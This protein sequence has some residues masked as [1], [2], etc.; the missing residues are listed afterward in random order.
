MN[1]LSTKDAIAY[2][3]EETD[4]DVTQQIKSHIAHCEGCRSL[5]EDVSQIAEAVG[6]QPGEFEDPSLTADIM[7][8]I[9]ASDS[10]Q[11]EETPA[12]VA[13]IG[14]P[15]RWIGWA[16]AATVI[17]AIAVTAYLQFREAPASGD[18]TQ[19]TGVAARGGPDRP[20][21][22]DQW[23]SLK[24]F[25][26]ITPPGET[27]YLPVSENVSS[28]DAIAV[29]Y[30]DNSETPFKYLMVLA[31]DHSGSIYWYYPA[32]TDESEDPAS[33]EIEDEPD[34]QFL[35]D[36]VTHDL[37]TGPLTFFGIFSMTPLHVHAV[38]SLLEKQIVNAKNAA[39]VKRLDIEDVAQWSRR[40][41]VIE[42]K[43]Q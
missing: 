38:E 22:M 40:V 2:V 35:P 11:T 32:Y 15:Y 5:V 16:A 24:L 26:K 9:E 6:A 17:A 43:T 28:R 20:D 31:V 13:Q 21:R 42:G 18:G 19:M 23:V 33:I 37:P 41:E 7:S 10:K 14:A 39:S 36:A 25:T 30:K 34:L 29:A 3:S 8:Q 1:C 12:S 4:I 27:L